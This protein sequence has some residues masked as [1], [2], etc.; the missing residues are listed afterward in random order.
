MRVSHPPLPTAY[1]HVTWDR[2]ELPNGLCSDPW[3]WPWPWR[4]TMFMY[5][6]CAVN[7]YDRDRD[8]EV[9]LCPWPV[10]WRDPW[11]DLTSLHYPDPATSR[12]GKRTSTAPVRLG[13]MLRDDDRDTGSLC[14]HEMTW[15]RDV[16]WY[17]VIQFMFM[18][19]TL[20]MTWYNQFALPRCLWRWRWRD[21]WRP[22]A[23]ARANG[24]WYPSVIAAYHGM[25]W[26]DVI[27][28]V[29]TKQDT[30]GV[31]RAPGPAPRP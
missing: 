1:A 2:A 26:R 28:A 15:F 17:D 19:M 24:S 18:P 5:C 20:T 10:T 8:R 7:A 21:P 30:Y 25:P 31:M 27:A 13:V 11:R 16:V 4:Q 3:L 29:C 6:F 23:L 9:C 12:A 22:F 14:S